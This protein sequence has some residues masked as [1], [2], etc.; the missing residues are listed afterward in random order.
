MGSALNNTLRQVGA[1]LGIALVSSLLV[2]ASLQDA[3]IS[4]FHRA[5]MI[6]AIVIVLS[7]FVMLALFRK[8]TAAQLHAAA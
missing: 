7:G 6:T 4:G 5:W 2:S 8:P 3:G 1:A